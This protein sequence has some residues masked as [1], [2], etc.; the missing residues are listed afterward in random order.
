MIKNKRESGIELLKIIAIFL[1]VIFHVTKSLSEVDYFNNLGFSEG[2]LLFAPTK[3]FSSFL[4]MLFRYFGV[5]GNFIF[6]ITSSYFLSKVKVTNKKKVLSLAINTIL[7]SWIFLFIFLIS[8]TDVAKH[9]IINSVFP[10]T[11][12]NNWFI[13]A[14]LLFILLI[15]FLNIV[16]SKINQIQHFRI[17]LISVILYFVIAFV[18]ANKAFYFNQLIYFIV[19]YFII[20]YFKSY[21][22]SFWNFKNSLILLI[23][24]ILCLILF[25]LAVNFV[26]LKFSILTKSQIVWTVSNNPIVFVIAISLF[27][28]FKIMKFKSNFINSFSSLS[29]YIYLI[30]ENLLFRQY[31]RTIIWHKIYETIGYRYIILE[32]IIYSIILFVLSALASFIYKLTVEK[33]VKI[34]IEKLLKSNRFKAL[35]KRIDSHIL[36]ANNE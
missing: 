17:C 36:K 8:K 9:N 26:G 29:L 23:T 18:L 31:T 1:I 32:I 7:I 30:H 15:P 33:L 35:I 14:Y 4:M 5:L 28:L 34:I 21:S 6:I 19:I 13:T 10:F 16:L 20:N 25:Q 12:N 27:Y 24:S 2:F 3:D 11:F 22:E